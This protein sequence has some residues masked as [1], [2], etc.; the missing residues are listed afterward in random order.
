MSCLYGGREIGAFKLWRDREFCSSDHRKTYGDGLIMELHQ[1]PGP[2]A[3]P[4]GVAGFTMSWPRQNG[5]A[6]PSL[7]R[8]ETQ[9]YPP[10]FSALFGG[11]TLA[12]VDADESAEPVPPFCA[13]AMRGL[14]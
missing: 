7:H 13:R 9:A 10:L 8:W 11:L 2:E 4:A 5:S 12:L 14:R 6:L 3:P 1:I